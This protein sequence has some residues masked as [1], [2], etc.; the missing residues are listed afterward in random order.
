MLPLTQFCDF[1]SNLLLRK[2]K[3]PESAIFLL[4]KLALLAIY[5]VI[6]IMINLRNDIIRKRIVMKILSQN[7]IDAILSNDLREPFDV[8]GMHREKNGI[9]IRVFNPQARVVKLCQRGSDKILAAMEQI[10][11]HGIFVAHFPDLKKFFPY[12]LIITDHD[13]TT[14]ITPDPYSFLPV[15]SEEARYLFNEGNH[16]KVY[17]DLGAHLREIDGV[18]G[19]VFAVWAP[20]A[21]RVS[22]VG[23]FNNWDGRQHPMR[24][25]GTSGVWELFIPGLKTH[26][27]YKYEIK[28]WHQDSLLLKSDP[29]GCYQE[30]F[31]YHGSIVFDLS[32][33]AW[34]DQQWLQQ[35]ASQDLLNRPMSIYEVHLGSWSK[36]GP[37]ENDYLS[38]EHLAIQLADYVN[39][40]GFTHIELMPVQEHPYVPSWGYQVTG[41]YSP[42][43]RFGN[44][45]G[46]QWFVNYMHKQGIGV[47]L[48]WVIGHFPKDLHGL[49]TFDGTHLYEHQDPRE[50]EHQDWGTHIFNYGRHEVR[51]FLTANAL[52]WCDKFHLDGLRVDAV[53]SM[54]YRNYSRKEGEWIP[55]QYG[56]VENIEAIECLQSVNYL[57]HKDY[58][59]VVTIAEE[60]TAWPMVT[61]P[62]Y[63]G[64]LGFTFKWNMG[65]MHDVLTYFTMDPIYRKYNHNQITFSLW[66]AFTE[67]FVLV[68]SHDEVVHGK[69]S[70]LEKMPG[71]KWFKFANL[72]A[73]YTFMYGHPGKK[74]LFQGSEFAMHN[75]WYESRSIDWHIINGEEDSFY[76][77]GMMR[78]LSD[79]NQVYKNEPALWEV[80]FE[81]HG[82]IWI[83]NHDYTNSIVSFIRQGHEWHNVLIVICN[84]TPVLR[85]TYKIGV[86]HGG[87]YQEI[88]NSDAREYGGA[89]YGNY[90]GKHTSHIPWHGK[91][92]SLDLCLPPLG[93]I[94]LKWKR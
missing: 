94:I 11:D 30:P 32:N 18:N 45:A 24:P 64:G 8:L 79:L 25:L 13:E 87:F 21:K 34:E 91:S 50:R 66:Y 44:P 36:S 42:N 61:N 33:F 60:S 62:T 53:A 85:Q 77:Y 83:D 22:V 54:L 38:Y 81:P 59:G 51:N 49:S 14:T 84:F 26:T 52:Y 10:A 35:R 90:G 7:E 31:P 2:N 93:V 40:I 73:L 75:E 71:D 6:N 67:N 88:F 63:S 19:V 39:K 17:N 47:I 15:M 78:L 28:L 89:G 4:K 70:L 23:S 72:R 5:K 43:H 1:I 29:Y 56:G 12:D 37:G 9:S 27:I 57:V 76:H 58:P 41:F 48:D 74:L 55:N 65:W 20:N 80:D 68:L 16:Y 46:F 86:P 82:F 69:H 3:L 92:C